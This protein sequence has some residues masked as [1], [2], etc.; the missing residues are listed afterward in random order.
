MKSYREIQQDFIDKYRI[1]IVENSKCRQRTH[2]HVKKRMICKWEP[3]SSIQ[4]TFTLLHEIGHCET[5][6]GWM[7]RC[8]SEYYATQWA[9]DR[10]R[11]LGLD[12][13][14]KEIDSY[15]RYIYRELD[16]GLRRY[17]S[18]YPS[19]EEMKLVK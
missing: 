4:S 11:E 5:F 16:R 7:R 6:K 13:P 9:L 17:G 18:G 15:Q 8:E 1:T 14:D 12:V 2:A 10:C 3:A 19:K